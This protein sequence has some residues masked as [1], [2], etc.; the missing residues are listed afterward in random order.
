MISYI[1]KKYLCGLI[2][3]TIIATLAAC[4]NIQT[5]APDENIT[6]DSLNTNTKTPESKT[7]EPQ[8]LD[9]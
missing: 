1:S 9:S 7:K 8:L 3:L 4:K 6:V 2:I 5:G